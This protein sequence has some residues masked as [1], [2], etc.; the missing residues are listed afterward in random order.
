MHKRRDVH[1]PA[2]A[3][4]RADWD[5]GAGSGACCGQLGMMRARN[6]QLPSGLGNARRGCGGTAKRTGA[7]QGCTHGDLLQAGKDEGFCAEGPGGGDM[8]ER[9]VRLEQKSNGQG[10]RVH[11]EIGKDG[12]ERT[13]SPNE[14]SPTGAA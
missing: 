12:T 7:V 5:C 2:G 6:G 3:C 8:G 14:S 4:T 10:M 1:G 11:P 9:R 13:P